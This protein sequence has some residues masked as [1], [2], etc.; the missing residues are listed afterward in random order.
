MYVYVDNR[1]DI[2][3]LYCTYN[4]FIKK[5]KKEKSSKYMLYDN[6]LKIDEH[7]KPDSLSGS[8]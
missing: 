5:K 6:V 8:S 7:E 1:E 2:V 3:F 4:Y